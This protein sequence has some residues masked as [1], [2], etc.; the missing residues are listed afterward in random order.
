MTKREKT[1][2]KRKRKKEKLAYVGMS[3]DFIHH[4]H[5]NIITKARKYGEVVIG[6]LTNEAIA[7]YKR[8]PML[9]YQQR[10]KILTNIV[11]V[12]KILPQ[13]TLDYVPNL[14][15]I[16]PDYV[17]HGDDWKTSV[18][19]ETRKRVVEVL[20]EWGGEL[21]EPKY[22]KDISSTDITNQILK[23]GITP[24]QRQKRLR[25][26]LK[27][28]P[29]MRVME[30]HS[31]LTGLIVEKTKLIKNN[32]VLEFDGIW[33]SSLTDSTSKGKPDTAAVDV[34]SRIN[35]IEEVLEIT[36]KPIIVDGDSGGLTEHFVYTVKTLERLG[37]SAIIIE[38]KIGSKR[39]SLF[40]TEAQQFQD[41]VKNFSQKITSGKR[42]QI[43]DDFMIIARIE[44]LILKAGMD[45]ALIRA[46]AYI[47]AGVDGIMIHSKEKNPKEI[48][49]FCREYRK[50][51]HRVPLVT[52]PST[53]SKITEREL[54]K[55]GVR[56]VIY[57]NQLLRSA[58]PAMKKVAETILKNGRASEVEADCMSIKDILTLISP[59]EACS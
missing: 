15:K 39:N 45:D 50:L 49:E 28:K 56:I 51:K 26:I 37:V 52:V 13:K 58:Y 23:Q 31:G 9:S 20:K 17:V 32:K 22:T 40:G 5:I 7:S 35:T 57:A 33:I 16:K 41:D 46:S 24:H 27:V 2:K 21:I 36:T 18:Q 12:K 3:A 1:L 42:A 48:L 25:K 19:A 59:I 30:A 43:T 38:D 53:Y 4:G 14:R 44:S 8:V 11:G 55:A 29:L 54:E 34:T 10:K 6:L 47:K